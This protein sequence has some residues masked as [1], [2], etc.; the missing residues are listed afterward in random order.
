[1]LGANEVA[2]GCIDARRH[3]RGLNK[4]GFVGAWATETQES[5][6]GTALASVSEDASCVNDERILRDVALVL[7]GAE[8]QVRPQVKKNRRESAATIPGEPG[9]SPGACE[10]TNPYA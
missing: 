5:A 9:L 2:P 6:A 3:P 10:C 4:G 7:A 1:M 8:A